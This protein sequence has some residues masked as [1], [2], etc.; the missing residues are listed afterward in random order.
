[1]VETAKRKSTGLVVSLVGF[2]HTAP[3]IPVL[4]FRT[5]IEKM[6]TNWF[7][8]KVAAIARDDEKADIYLTNE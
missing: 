3:D 1:V 6:M 7:G 5:S 4:P 2:D 8:M